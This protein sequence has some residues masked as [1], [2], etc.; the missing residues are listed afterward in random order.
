MKN[1]YKLKNKGDPFSGMIIKHDM[2]R[3]DRE[4]ER[5]LQKEAREKHRTDNKCCLPSKRTPRRKAN[6]Q[7][8]EKGRNNQPNSSTAS[9]RTGETVIWYTNADVLTKEKSTELK[10]RI[11]NHSTSPHV[12]AISAVKPKNYKRKLTMQEYN[13]EGYS[14]EAMNIDDGKGRGMI[15]FIHNSFRLKYTILTLILMKH[16]FAL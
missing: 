7:G 5:L 6:H 11:K 13:L 8:K 14:N 1:L 16:N 15:L 2:S 12:V 4:K 3:D 9:A 10:C